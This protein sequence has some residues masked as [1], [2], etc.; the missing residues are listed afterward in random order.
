M[1][2]ELSGRTRVGA[3]AAVAAV[4]ILA[5]GCLFNAVRAYPYYFP[6]INGLSFGRPAYTL[7]NDSNV[8]WNQSLPRSAALRG[9]TW[10]KH[11]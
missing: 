1:L 3:A 2:V 9:T 4:V 6:Y 5:A 7:V 10:T 11:N 8:D